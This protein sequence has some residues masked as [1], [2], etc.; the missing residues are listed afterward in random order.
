MV[1]HISKK[2]PVIT[3]LEKKIGMLQGLDPVMENIV[4]DLDMVT[5]FRK[6]NHYNKMWDMHNAHKFGAISDPREEEE[7]PLPYWHQRY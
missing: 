3:Q 5:D 1:E 7:E 4:H 2:V 6:I